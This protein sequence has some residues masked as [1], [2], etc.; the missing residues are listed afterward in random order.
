MNRQYTR[1][2]A[3]DIKLINKKGYYFEVDFTK[4]GHHGSYYPEDTILSFWIAGP[5]LNAIIPQRHTIASA[6]STLDLIPMV[7]YLLD[8]PQPVGL[9][10]QKS[11]GRLETL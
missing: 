1:E 10:W 11:P 8:M 5:G 3:P 9:Q 4:Y 2:T 6:T 7:T